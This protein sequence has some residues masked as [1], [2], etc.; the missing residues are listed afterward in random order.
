M[1]GR[2]SAMGWLGQMVPGQAGHM[3]RDVGIAFQ[4]VRGFVAD[5]PFDI[6]VGIGVNTHSRRRGH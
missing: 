5:H 2:T 4:K 1:T 6:D 3:D